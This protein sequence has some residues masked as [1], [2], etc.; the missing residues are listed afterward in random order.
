MGG[1]VPRDACRPTE[2]LLAPFRIGKV[3]TDTH[4]LPDGGEIEVSADRRGNTL[5]LRARSVPGAIRR[6]WACSESSW[7]QKDHKVGRSENNPDVIVTVA[8]R[9]AHDAHRPNAGSRGIAGGN[10][11][12]SDGTRPNKANT[13][14]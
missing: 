6:R 11:N 5:R 8:D 9:R 4:R 7:D 14:N 13:G 2:M 1:L 3:Y 12:L 10:V